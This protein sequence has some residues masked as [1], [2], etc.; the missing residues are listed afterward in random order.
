[1]T[2][3]QNCNKKNINKNKIEFRILI[4]IIELKNTM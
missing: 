2:K 3:T 4:T 1:M